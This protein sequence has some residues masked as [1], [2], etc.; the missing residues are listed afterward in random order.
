LSHNDKWLFG[1]KGLRFEEFSFVNEPADQG[2]KMNQE[3]SY[4]RKACRQCSGI[5]DTATEPC[6]TIRYEQ[7]ASPKSWI[8]TDQ[9]AHYFHVGCFQEVAG[10][11]FMW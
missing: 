8:Q 1:Y 2:M 7:A 4:A 10:D 9:K 11:K 5:I 3:T 6:Y